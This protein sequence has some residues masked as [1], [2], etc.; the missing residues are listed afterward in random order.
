MATWPSALAWLLGGSCGPR[1]PPTPYLLST[2]VGGMPQPSG[3][4]CLPRLSPGWVQA[5]ALSP[6][7]LGHSYQPWALHWG[8]KATYC[9]RL[10]SRLGAAIVGH[11]PGHQGPL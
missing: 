8:R 5:S 7:I 6:T 2:R 9:S 1:L 4:L 10:E 11:R 3:Y